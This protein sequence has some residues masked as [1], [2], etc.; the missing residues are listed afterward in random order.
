MLKTIS[1]A[2]LVLVAGAASAASIS[3]GP[4]P[5]TNTDN[6]A[7]ECGAS[8]SCQD[9]IATSVVNQYLSPWAGGT[10][11]DDGFTYSSVTGTGSI[12][13][14]IDATALS[15]VWGSPDDYN[16]LTLL[17]DGDVV[18]S[19]AYPTTIGSNIPDSLFTVSG[20]LFDEVVF[21]SGTP[22]FEFANLSVAAVP[23]P[24]AGVLLL[25]ALGALGIARRRKA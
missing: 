15:F 6:P 14:G 20:V 9:N 21:A 22:A 7:L 12:D 18:F 24:A 25:G 17:D 23:L 13:L 1:A 3:W 10:A 4:T 11:A 2:A 5:T 8:S 16:T 19:Y